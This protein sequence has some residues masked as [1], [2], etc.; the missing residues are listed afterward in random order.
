MLESLAERNDARIGLAG[1][2]YP[3]VFAG[4]DP[5]LLGRDQLPWLKESAR[6]I[7]ERATNWTIVPVPAPGLGASSSIR[8]STRT[9]A[10]ERLWNELWHVLRLDEADPGAAWDARI[11]DA[12]AVGRARSPTGDST[13]SSCAAR[14][15][16]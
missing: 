4:L 9:D 14:A 1:L 8:S 15:P 10:Y 5:A 13:R 7:G 3:D 2:V 11:G 16:S 6:V 12:E